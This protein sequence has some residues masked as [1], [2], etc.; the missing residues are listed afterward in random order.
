MV[1]WP[2]VLIFCAVALVAGYVWG[3]SNRDS[4]R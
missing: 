1:V 4:R 2:L 3:W